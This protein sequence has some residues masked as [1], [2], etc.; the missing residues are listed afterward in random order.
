MT[1]KINFNLQKLHTALARYDDEIHD[2]LASYREGLAA[3]KQEAALYRDADGQL[4][5]MKETLVAPAR[6]RI[7]AADATLAKT[8]GE[9]AESLREAIAARVTEQPDGDFVNLMRTCGELGVK[10]TATELKAFVPAT[11]GNY[12]ALRMLA[13]L[14]EKSGFKMNVPSADEYE[15]TV[16]DIERLTRIPLMVGQEGL[17]AEA[18]DVL[19]NRPVFANNGTLIYST[20]RPDAG[21]VASVTQAHKALRKRIDEAAD[22]WDAEFVPLLCELEPVT[23]DDG[24]EISPAEQRAEAVKKAA[25]AID[26]DERGAE[27]VAELEAA[28]NAQAERKA[29]RIRAQFVGR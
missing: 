14:A 1:K 13:T 19:P 25:D 20:G 7:A 10:L 4:A 27:H 22:H 2:V 5:R 9:V 12:L 6:A 29:A 8:A 21:Y 26:L 23:G 28:E 16:R 17:W 15:K 11:G 18:A 24:K 3:A